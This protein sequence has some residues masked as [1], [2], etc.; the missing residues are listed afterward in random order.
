MDEIFEPKNTIIVISFGCSPTHP[1]LDALGTCDNPDWIHI[2]VPDD[3]SRLWRS[4]L[5][6]LINLGGLTDKPYG[7]RG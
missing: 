3:Q 2:A 7:N 4:G 5:A 6:Q 1:Q